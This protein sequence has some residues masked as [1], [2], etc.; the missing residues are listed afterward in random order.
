M[1]IHPIMENQTPTLTPKTGI[2]S[3]L[4]YAVLGSVLLYFGKALFVPLS[5][6]LLISFL[7]YPVCRWMER[8]GLHRNLA[9]V[10]SVGGVTL[11]LVAILDLLV[12]QM[13]GFYH[14]WEAIR[15]K[16]LESIGQ[17]SG[18]LTERFGLSA[19][20]QTE[21][22]KNLI[23]DSGNRAFS[24]LQST[25]YFFSEAVFALVLIPIFSALILVYREML[26]EVLYR[27][28]PGKKRETLHE[29]LVETIHAY[30]NF[31]KGMLL[32][33]LIVGMLNSLGLWI[34][35][36]PHPF[37][38]GF[39]ASILTFI[40]YVGILVAS[41]LPIFIS[42]ITFNSILYPIYV[43]LVFSIVQILEAYIIFPFAVGGSL[44]IN[45]LV[46]MV[47]ILAGG[48]LWGGAG[49]ILFIPFVSIA[50]LVADRTEGLETLAL[51]LGDGKTKKNAP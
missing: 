20:R 6:S 31:I 17:L 23:R 38:F 41:L 40:P 16:L 37:L 34:I 8:M 45:T 36:V 1:P 14:E 26:A 39:I 15:T 29:I 2:R 7:L 49:M 28:F 32:V 43:V 5:F 4:E 35:G 24:L 3:L 47:M 13:I 48:I 50:K 27:L 44:K 12:L 19:A 11:L 25:A 18:F 42:W 10:I 9:I 21:L 46:I 30:Y 22:L 33:Y 51:L